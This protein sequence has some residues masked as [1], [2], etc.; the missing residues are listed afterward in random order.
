MEEAANASSQAAVFQQGTARKPSAAG[1][2]QLSSR[3]IRDEVRA[4]RVGVRTQVV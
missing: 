3:E 1:A 4:W 2:E